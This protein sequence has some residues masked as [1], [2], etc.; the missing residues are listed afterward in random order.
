[1]FSKEF[2]KRLL[3]PD[4]PRPF[5]EYK[6]L[7]TVVN[8]KSYTTMIEW[9]SILVKK[10]FTTTPSKKDIQVKM[11]WVYGFR[12]RDVR[13]PL[14]YIKTNNGQR[15]SNEK[16]LFFTACIIIVYFPKLNE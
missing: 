3:L 12:G 11:N 16:L 1:M 5:F 7:S 6:P 2:G 4:D 15:A 8:S 14:S 13:R 9:I 10:V